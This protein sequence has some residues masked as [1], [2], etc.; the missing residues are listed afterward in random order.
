[1]RLPI[2]IVF[3]LMSLGLTQTQAHSL[4]DS[5]ALLTLNSTSVKLEFHTPYEILELAFKNKINLD[6]PNCL[7][8][9]KNYFLTHISI[10]DSLGSKWIVT[11]GRIKSQE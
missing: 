8:S 6:S 2:V 1:M 10:S 4:P 9:L 3:F 7:D 11:V 5:K